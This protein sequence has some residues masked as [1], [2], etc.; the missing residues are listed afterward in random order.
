VENAGLEDAAGE[1]GR[2]GGG[3]GPGE[4]VGEVLEVDEVGVGVGAVGGGG[5][6]AV[7]LGGWLVVKLQMGDRA[8][9]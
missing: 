6:Y 9:Y 1:V 3:V 8:T 5:D 7:E 2:G 4:G